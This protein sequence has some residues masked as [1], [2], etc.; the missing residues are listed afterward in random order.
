MKTRLCEEGEK[1][2]AGDQATRFLIDSGCTPEPQCEPEFTA[3]NS[4]KETCRVTQTHIRAR[5]FKSQ[6][7]LPTLSLTI[8]H[9]N[10]HVYKT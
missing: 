1:G 10:A 4:V 7:A 8:G 6:V 9:A 5:K 2:D 3:V